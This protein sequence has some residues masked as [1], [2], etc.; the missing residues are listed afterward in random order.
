MDFMHSCEAMGRSEAYAGQGGAAITCA[1]GACQ[2][3]SPVFAIAAQAGDNQ[4]LGL[5]SLGCLLH[6]FPPL[7]KPMT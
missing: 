1:S 7:H 2:V 5:L 3:V 4:S 6:P